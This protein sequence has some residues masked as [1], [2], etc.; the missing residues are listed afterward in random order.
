MSKEPSKHW[1]HLDICMLWLLIQKLSFQFN[2]FYK[3][4]INDVMQVGI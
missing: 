1:T 2:L 4:V 3:W